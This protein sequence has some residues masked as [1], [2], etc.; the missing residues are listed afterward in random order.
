[1]IHFY[2]ETWQQEKKILTDFLNYLKKY[3]SAALFSYSGFD[4]GVLKYALKRHNLDVDFFLNLNHYDLCA[5]IKQN[6]IFPLAGYGLKEIGRFMG[7]KFMNPY[8]D[9]F[10]ASREYMRSQ[11]L[12]EIISNELL[13]Y[14]EDDVKVMDHIIT[15]LQIEKN[16]KNLFDIINR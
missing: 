7:Y 8:Y 10:M 2:A 13:N 4:V 6:Y 11:R 12:G 15:Q 16:I 9:G 5:I 14:I 3:K 1:M